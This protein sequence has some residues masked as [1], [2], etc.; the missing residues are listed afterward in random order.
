MLSPVTS[1]SKKAKTHAKRIAAKKEGTDI[2]K[3]EKKRAILSNQLP[4]KT[5]HKTPIVIP[6]IMAKNM[7]TTA[8]SAVFGKASDK[9]SITCRL[10]WYER[11][12][13]GFLSTIGNSQTKGMKYNGNWKDSNKK[14]SL[15]L[16]FCAMIL[17]INH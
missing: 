2:P 14:R 1:A 16:L 12:I 6:T 3:T 8:K 10:L 17:V 4:L 9:I 11:L 13:K 5:A 15:Y 7:E